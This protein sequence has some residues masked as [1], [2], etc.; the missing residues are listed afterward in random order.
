MGFE[1]ATLAIVAFLHLAGILH[2]G[3]KPFRPTDAGIAEAI[4]GVA[5]TY[6]ASTLVRAR[7][8][9]RS[10]AVATTG[11]AILGF[12]VGLNFT[13]RGGDAIDIAYHATMLPLLLLTLIALLRRKAD[14]S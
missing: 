5:L 13:V 6:G 12:I 9:A 11:F 7:A 10:I 1:T 14:P 3:S 2:G 8:H 4:I